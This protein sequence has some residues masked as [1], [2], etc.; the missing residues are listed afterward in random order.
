LF[1]KLAKLALNSLRKNKDFEI[2][3]S[4]NLTIIRNGYWLWL[5]LKLLAWTEEPPKSIFMQK[6][7]NE[8]ELTV[9]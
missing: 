4:T 1:F 3:D 8:T 5:F 7:L 9:F 2:Q 6:Q